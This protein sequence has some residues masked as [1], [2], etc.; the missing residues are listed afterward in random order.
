MAYEWNPV[1]L[2]TDLISFC[3]A[4]GVLAR[5]LDPL[6]FEYWLIPSLL[7]HGMWRLCHNMNDMTLCGGIHLE[8]TDWIHSFVAWDLYCAVESN[9]QGPNGSFPLPRQQGT[10]CCLHVPSC[11]KDQRWR[12]RGCLPARRTGVGGGAHM[13]CDMHRWTY[14]L[15]HATHTLSPPST[16]LW[17]LMT[18][19]NSC[20]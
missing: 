13:P 14:L 20:W 10:W 4:C 5:S 15:P 18:A 3:L 2:Q 11:E 8:S 9:H 1:L 16:L 6:I 12:I 19:M 17:I 7:D